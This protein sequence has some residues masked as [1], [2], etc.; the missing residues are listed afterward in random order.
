MFAASAA[1]NKDCKIAP[2]K[3]YQPQTDEASSCFC[4]LQ[5]CLLPSLLLKG[6][7]TPPFNVHP[8]GT[9]KLNSH[10][11][12]SQGAFSAAAEGLVLPWAVI[13]DAAVDQTTSTL[14]RHGVPQLLGE[15]PV[16]R[17]DTPSAG[18][19]CRTRR[20]TGRGRSCP[21]GRRLLLAAALL[22]RGT[23]EQTRAG[24]CV[25]R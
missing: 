24:L 3:P 6:E 10:L 4:E 25:T 14:K 16:R 7:K 5:T 18:R 2:K 13:L 12:R 23:A 15:K 22:T 9:T 20:V 11:Q 1:F 17:L 19:G 21:R 8:S